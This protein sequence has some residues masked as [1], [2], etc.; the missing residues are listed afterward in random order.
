MTFALHSHPALRPACL[1]LSLVAVPFASMAAPTVATSRFQGWE[2]VS[3]SN[4]LIE[5]QVVP[6]I[7]GRVISLRFGQ[8]DFLFCNEALA[9]RTS[10]PSGVG[11]NGEWLNYGGEKLWPAPQ[12]R[13][14]LP[15]HWN[16][17][18]DPILDGGPHSATIIGSK[19]GVAGLRLASQ[20]DQRSGIRFSREIS[21]Y[22]DSTRVR[23]DATMTNVSSVVR[24]WGIWSVLQQ[25]A[26][27]RAGEGFD[28][29]IR[30]YC[31]LRS[32]SVH[33]GG[34]RVMYGPKDSTSFIADRAKQRLM[35]RYERNMGKVGIDSDAGWIA[36]VHGSAGLVLVQRYTFFPEREYPDHAA[37][38]IWLHGPYG[39]KAAQT[40]E[41]TFPYFVETELLSPF[42]ELQ[43]ENSFTFSYDWYATSIG[44]NYEIVD[45]ND[46]GAVSEPLAVSFRGGEGVVTGRFGVFHRGTVVLVAEDTTGQPIG[47][48]LF[49]QEATP[50][51]AVVISQHLRTMPSET[52]SLALLLRDP[53][54]NLIGRLG[55]A[56][57][58]PALGK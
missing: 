32:K 18:P 31:P 22:R 33:E 15:G 5:L 48:P 20:A 45:C 16:G 58:R 47:G 44:G 49:Q 57:V 8:F 13:D 46:A 28:P 17:P 9:G 51:E 35:A 39:P 40:D 52:D 24:R 12:G 26:A 53:E 42:A 23:I 55:L 25:N 4:N 14:G 36:T 21:L 34:Y 6:A 19:D 29:S 11:P 30:I 56:M 50:L 38:E 10:G 2:A 27:N 54:G 3:L 41:K 43:P 7:G 1:G 37:V